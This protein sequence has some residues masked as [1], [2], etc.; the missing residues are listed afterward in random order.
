[1]AIVFGDG[2]GFSSFN[3]LGYYFSTAAGGSLGD[4]SYATAFANYNL[5]H[6]ISNAG[7]NIGY[8]F[9]KIPDSQFDDVAKMWWRMKSYELSDGDLFRIEKTL[10][11][12]PSGNPTDV[13]F[14]SGNLSWDQLDGSGNILY[15]DKYR[16]RFYL[17]SYE[18][19]PLGTGSDTFGQTYLGGGGTNGEQLVVFPT[20]VTGDI[21]AFHPMNSFKQGIDSS[22]NQ[23]GYYFGYIFK[24]G[25]HIYYSS[26]N[27]TPDPRVE[28]FGGKIIEIAS[29]VTNSAENSNWEVEE[30]VDIEIGGI[31]FKMK[32]QNKINDALNPTN[33][34]GYAETALGRTNSGAESFL[35]TFKYKPTASDFDSTS[36]FSFDDYKNNG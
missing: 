33:S 21:D 22:G 18:S 12:Q 27:T 31:D 17:P 23:D 25:F 20:R 7:L 1:M 29:F 19:I 4:A 16:N 10:Q 34:T 28:Y 8:S 26:V 14:Y 11:S 13:S 6:Q 30:I 24:Y 32:I 5:Y 35:D 2:S 15:D 9:N 3:N 36:F